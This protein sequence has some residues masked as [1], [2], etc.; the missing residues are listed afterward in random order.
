MK[1]TNFNNT[2]FIELNLA[3]MTQVAGG[4][5]AGVREYLHSIVQAVGDFFN[6][7]GC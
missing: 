7:P 1:M 3:E 2:D 5:G 4:W 6:Q